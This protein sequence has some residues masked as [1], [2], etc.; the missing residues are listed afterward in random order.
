MRKKIE[1]KKIK[2]KKKTDR[3]TQKA[4]RTEKKGRESSATAL[5]MSSQWVESLSKSLFINSILCQNFHTISLRKRS[6][7]LSHLFLFAS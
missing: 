6:K 5:E 2:E 7:G 4:F 1:E 3:E